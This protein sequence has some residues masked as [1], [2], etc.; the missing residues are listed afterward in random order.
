MLET[1]IGLIVLVVALTCYAL[2]LRFGP[3]RPPGRGA[4]RAKRERIKER[5][6]GDQTDS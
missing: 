1:I 4:P 3:G 2:A 6:V 5:N